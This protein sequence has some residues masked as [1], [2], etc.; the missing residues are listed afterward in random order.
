VSHGS[1]TVEPA[2]AADY[3]LPPIVHPDVG[4]LTGPDAAEL[5]RLAQM[6]GTPLHVVFPQLMQE[7]IGRFRRSMTA[8]GDPDGRIYYA[9]KAS[10]A[11]SFLSVAAAEAIGADVSSKQEF[12]AAL[13][14]SVP[15]S[16]ISVSGPAKPAGLLDQAAAHGALTA[17]DQP[18]ELDALLRA[19]A[20]LRTRA[21][22]RV[23]LRLTAP[24]S[25]LG[26]SRADAS[27][28]LRRIAGL[29]SAA[30]LEGLAF[31]APG[32]DT[33]TR[34][35]MIAEACAVIAEAAGLGLAPA[36][37]NIGG[38]LAVAYA[39]PAGWDLRLAFD[40]EFAAGFRPGWAYP[41]TASPAGP[42]QLAEILRAS[43]EPLAKASAAA[44]RPVAVDIEPGRSLLDQAGITVFGV[45]EIQPYGNRWVVVV[46]GN[47]SHVSEARSDSEPFTDPLLITAGPAAAE[48]F[49]AAVADC[50]CLENGWLIH[51]FV[52]F[53]ARP[54]PGD[55]IAFVNT[56]GYY[57]DARQT[58]FHRQPLPRKVAALRSEGGWRFTDDSLVGVDDVIEGVP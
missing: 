49:C 17:L 4:R 46:D 16:R 35:A 11:S 20:R 38:G 42:E 10:R 29:G 31:H 15:G 23:S 12:D 40:R 51:R 58:E 8:A 55:L 36:R 27:A 44:G 50:T 1:P 13:N 7:A 45:R 2:T 30:A 34:V 32:Y 28:A 18:S 3:P 26:M 19:A 33:S 21:P 22:V 57:A 14:H 25:R 48:P 9:V 47:K 56:A 37:I 43:R 5:R 6:L 54:G 53:P 24:G 52:P 39:D 41:C